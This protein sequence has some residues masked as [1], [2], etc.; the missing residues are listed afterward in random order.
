MAFGLDLLDNGAVQCL[1]LFK[2]LIECDL[3]DFGSHGG[4]GEVRD[5]REQVLDPVAGL[6]RVFDLNVE[7][8][9]NVECHVVLRDGMLRGNM[10]DLFPEVMGVG[11][12]VD[13]GDFEVEAWLHLAVVF[14]EAVEQDGVLLVHHDENAKQVG[15]GLRFHEKGAGRKEGGRWGAGAGGAAESRE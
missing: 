5:G 15:I 13:E 1:A 3:S 8:A 2:G 11:D 9:I 12:G 4:L 14:I 7:D 6:I 10:H